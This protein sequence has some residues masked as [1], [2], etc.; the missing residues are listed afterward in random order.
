MNNYLKLR[1]NLKT[2][3]LIVKF[4]VLLLT[5]ESINAQVINVEKIRKQNEEGLKGTINLGFFFIDNG[6]KIST[7]K[8]LIEVQFDR[9]PHTYILINDLSLM[10]VDK[11]NLVNAGFQHLRYNYT[12]KD[13]SFF[14]VETFF[15]HQ[16]N[17]IKLLKKRLL[18]GFGPRFRLLRSPKSRIYIGALGM[19]ENETLSDSIET[20]RNIMRLGS[21]LSFR[22]DI[23][24]NLSFVNITYYQPAFTNF[25]NFRLSSETNFQIKITDSFSFRTGFQANYDSKPP[26]NIQKLFYNWENE[27]IYSF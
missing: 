4:L 1:I 13:S 14:T 7:F 21:Y 27:L 12:F 6:K 25:Q 17:T 26:E 16:Y 2:F 18:F 19:Y 5:F 23:L 11:D 20:R 22:W 9:G 24:K 8:N 10:R 15:Q 3:F